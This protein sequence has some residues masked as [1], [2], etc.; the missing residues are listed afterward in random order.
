LPIK[1]GVQPVLWVWEDRMRPT[2][3][4]S[5]RSVTALGLAVSAE[6][7]TM[8]VTLPSP[9]LVWVIRSLL[10][11]LLIATADG[12]WGRVAALAATRGT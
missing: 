10:P 11:V 3:K 7:P 5:D 4:T 8:R 12:W 9:A 2:C 6:V 1:I